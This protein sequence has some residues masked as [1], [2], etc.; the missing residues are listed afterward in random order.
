LRQHQSFV[1]MQDVRTANS[2]LHRCSQ[3]LL[4]S[5]SRG[6]NYATL[7]SAAQESTS[8]DPLQYFHSLYSKLMYS[9]RRILDK[10]WHRSL[11]CQRST[12]EKDNF[13]SE[14]FLIG[15]SGGCFRQRNVPRFTTLYV[16]IPS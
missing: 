2:F 3:G 14:C 10:Y 12:T 5:T 6:S 7:V 13:I 4:K 15:C 16:S 11:H 8:F 1:R 9:L